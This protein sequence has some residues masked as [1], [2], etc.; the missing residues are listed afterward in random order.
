MT[1][2]RYVDKDDHQHKE[3][4]EWNSC[5]MTMVVQRMMN[6]KTLMRIMVKSILSPPHSRGV[7]VGTLGCPSSVRRINR[8]THDLDDLPNI[9]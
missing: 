3:Y 9:F 7:A 2:I 4:G 5:I 8:P 6:Y 1:G